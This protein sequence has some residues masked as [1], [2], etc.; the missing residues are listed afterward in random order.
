M[1]KRASD[2]AARAG[3][4]SP[5]N[6][7]RRAALSGALVAGL[8][9]TGCNASGLAEQSVS[10]SAAFSLPATTEVTRESGR[11]VLQKANAFME[12]LSDTQ[13]DALVQRYT[14]A[15]AA[16]WHTY[17]QRDL[18]RREA[19]LGLSLG[20]LSQRQLQALN[21]LLTV[22]TG[23]S[24]NDGYDEIQQHLAADD[25]LRQNGGRDGYGREHFYVAFLETPTESDTWQLQF[26]GHHLALSNTYRGGVLVGATPSFRAIEPQAPIQHNGLV[27]A[28]QI[29][30]WKAFIEVLASLDSAQASAAKLSRSQ[31]ELLLG[32]ETGNKDWNFPAR[33]QGVAASA[34]SAKQRALLLKAISLYVNDVSDA[35]AA[36]ILGRYERELDTTHLSFSG[37]A[38]LTRAG[39]YVR[40]DGPSVWIEL[41][42]ERPYS[43]NQLHTH[44]VWRDKSTDYGGTRPN[45]G[46]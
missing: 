24:R 40:I 19:R 1:R 42:I 9:C 26:G 12:T 6:A 31:D 21:A 25:W 4:A 30:E 45:N 5:K 20:E 28:P 43:T 35:D 27:L 8:G 17:P 7:M 13:R 44:S 37:S 16:R 14:F 41:A 29:D 22:A 3:L 11:T 36:L 34:L 2:G 32:P 46:F 33:P 23:S 38:S 39:D 18:S 10:S 15:N